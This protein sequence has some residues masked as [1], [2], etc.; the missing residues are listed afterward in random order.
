[1]KDA[2]MQTDLLARS[3]VETNFVGNEA[4]NLEPIE[5]PCSPKV[6]QAEVEQLPPKHRLLCANKLQVYYAAA[7]EIP[8]LMREI[9][10]LREVTFRQVGEGTGKSIDLDIYDDYYLHLCSSNISNWAVSC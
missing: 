8:W 10:R 5:S 1:M 7:K 2:K 6:L 3:R 9:G 4:P